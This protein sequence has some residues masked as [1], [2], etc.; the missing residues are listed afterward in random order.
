LWSIY[1]QKL[2]EKYKEIRFVDGLLSKCLYLFFNFDWFH[3]R[4]LLY[5]FRVFAICTIPAS[6]LGNENLQAFFRGDLHGFIQKRSVA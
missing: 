3:A 4:I 2:R 1:C 6:I 5:H